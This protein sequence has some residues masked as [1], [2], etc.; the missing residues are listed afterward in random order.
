MASENGFL[1]V[2]DYLINKVRFGIPRAALLSILV[3][4]ELDGGMEYLS[5]EKDKVRLAYADMLKWYVLGASKV[6][7]TSDADN[8]WSHTEGGYELSSA[9]IG[10]QAQID[11]PYDFS[12]REACVP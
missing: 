4:R 8:N 7:N 10:V 3:D 6:N 12:R 11:L 5:C 1:S 2:T 9:D